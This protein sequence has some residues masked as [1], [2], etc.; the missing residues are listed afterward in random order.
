M[1]DWVHAKEVRQHRHLWLTLFNYVAVIQLGQGK[2]ISVTINSNKLWL[3]TIKVYLIL[4]HILM[5]FDRGMTS[6]GPWSNSGPKV[7]PLWTPQPCRTLN[8]YTGDSAFDQQMRQE[9]KD[10]LRRKALGLG[11]EEGAITSF[12]IPLDSS[13]SHD[14][15]NLEGTQKCSPAVCH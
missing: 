6:S 15:L 1:I 5:R 4:N 3:N 2:L 7:F 13:Q 12:P 10:G 14:P 11:A 9:R 8:S